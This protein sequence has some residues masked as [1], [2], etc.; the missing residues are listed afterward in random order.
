MNVRLAAVIPARLASSRLPGKALLKFHGL[1]MVE[2]TRRRALLAAVFS[3]VVVATCDHEIAD[4]VRRFGGKVI[5]T[6][7]AHLG[8]TDRVAEAMTQLDCTHVVNVQGDEMLIPPSDLCAMARAV[9]EEPIVPAWNAV[10][11]VQATEELAD[12]SIVK[13]MVSRSGRVMSCARDVSRVPHAPGWEPVRKSIGVMT[14][15]RDFIGR[16]VTL[17]RT[18]HEVAEG[19][20]QWRIIE[21]DFVLRTV[22]FPRAFVAINE[23]RE[24][25]L[26]E[27]CLERD[28]QQRAILE[29][30]LAT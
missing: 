29:Q 16:Y 6:S 15:T 24:V 23:A 27:A 2:H 20:D 3:D 19:I 4:E 28:P 25:P 12:P 17:P 1:P 9:T 21:H 18:P 22:E 7:P 30:V 11:C 8:A 5:M 10:A 14:Y 26:V 13:L